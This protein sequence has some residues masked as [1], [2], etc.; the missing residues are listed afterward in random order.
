MAA[1]KAAEVFETEHREG[2]RKRE[3]ERL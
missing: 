2:C 3:G 1:A